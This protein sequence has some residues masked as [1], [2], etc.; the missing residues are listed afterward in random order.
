VVT[1]LERETEALRS[2]FDL[3]KLKQFWRQVALFVAGSRL[4][5]FTRRM[6]CLLLLSTLVLACCVGASHEREFIYKSAVVHGDGGVDHSVADENKFQFISDSGEKSP[7]VA[8][9]PCRD[10]RDECLAYAAG[11]GCS[12]DPR[13]MRTHCPVACAVC[14]QRIT[15]VHRKKAF[16]HRNS[17]YSGVV[18]DGLR[19]ESLGEVPQRLLPGHETAIRDW[20]EQTVNYLE[21]VVMVEDRF[22]SVRDICQNLQTDCVYWATI[23][24]CDNNY[25]YMI[26]QCAPVCFECE[27]LHLEARCPIDPNEK[28]GT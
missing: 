15:Y 12:E 22:R 7:R 1:L 11:G 25:D 2:Y 13:W 18:H 6:P 28:H 10:L 20:F 17:V 16:G 23:G 21:E 26:E 14:D 5:S 24:E 9:G 8:A 4:D 19:D 27:Q 3:I